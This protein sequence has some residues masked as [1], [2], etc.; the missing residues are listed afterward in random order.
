M[1]MAKGL[2]TTERLFLGCA[3]WAGSAAIYGAGGL[4]DPGSLPTYDISTSD[5]ITV[6]AEDES[7]RRYGLRFAESVFE[8]AYETTGEPAGNGLVV[9]AARDEPHPLSLLRLYLEFGYDI[10]GAE[11]DLGVDPKL[12][13]ALRGWEEAERSVREEVGVE[14]DSV[15]HVIPM[16]LEGAVLK[17]YLLARETGFDEEATREQFSSLSL[18]ELQY[19]A[20]DEYDWVIYLPPRRALDEVLREVL[21]KAMKAQKVG[22]FKRALARGAVFALKP[23]IRDAMEGVRKSLLYDSILKGTSDLSAEE[24]QALTNAYREALM[25][26]GRLFAGRAKKRKD[27]LEAIRKE[28]GRE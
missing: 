16:P 21:P 23:V 12:S 22:F 5:R 28:M 14:L 6:F 3:L 7:A 27:A 15:I 19:R 11:D 4:D 24:R 1:S 13:E 10:E 8:A 2:A 17:L 18:S 25:P 26:K 20:F 9:I